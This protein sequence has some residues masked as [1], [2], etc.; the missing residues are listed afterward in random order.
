MQLTHQVS[1][2]KCNIIS[3]YETN[4][5]GYLSK[6]KTCT[7][8]SQI[9]GWASNV[10]NFFQAKH[11]DKKKLAFDMTNFHYATMH[12]HVCLYKSLP[13]KIVME[14]NAEGRIS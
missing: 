11:H 1:N 2:E 8:R 6:F 13:L 4:N 7:A 12:V 10:Q 9:N 3:S 5:H 14:P